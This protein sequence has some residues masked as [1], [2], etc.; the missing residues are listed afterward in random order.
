VIPLESEKY[1]DDGYLSIVDYH[2]DFNAFIPHLETLTLRGL[3]P[4][5]MGYV[6]HPPS[7]H[8]VIFRESTLRSSQLYHL[9]CTCL[10]LQVIGQ[11]GSLL[12]PNLERSGADD[13]GNDVAKKLMSAVMALK[14]YWTTFPERIGDRRQTFESFLFHA[15]GTTLVPALTSLVFR[16]I[17]VRNLSFAS[18][19]LSASVRTLQYLYI[20]FS[21]QKE[22]SSLGA[23]T[24]Q[25]VVYHHLTNH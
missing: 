16:A 10:S 15:E 5:Q 13:D 6:P 2:E 20:K 9:I 4:F 14:G 25:L 7:I 23:V 21:D 1:N 24:Y 12:L 17:K 22:M 18:M 19:L 11:T 8:T 3:T